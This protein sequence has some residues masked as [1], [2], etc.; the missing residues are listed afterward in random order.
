MLRMGTKYE[1]D[2]IKS[3]ALKRL[4]ECFPSRLQDFRSSMQSD[5]AF[6]GMD[7]AGVAKLVRIAN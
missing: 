3:L 1:M 5:Q 7:L 2:A 4:E 6:L